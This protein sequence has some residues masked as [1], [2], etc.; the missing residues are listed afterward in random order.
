MKPLNPPATDEKER[1][2]MQPDIQ[3]LTPEK[4]EDFF[5]FFEHIAFAHHPEWGCD[6][7]CCFFHAKSRKAW[8]DATRESNIKAAREMILAGGMRGLLAYADGK[9]VGWCHFDLLKNLPGA[10]VF[11]SE[12]ASD[13][14]KSAAIVCFTIA[15][16]YR[17]Q[18]VATKLL[19]KAMEELKELGVTRVEAYP[20]IK[21]ESQ[22]HNYLGPIAMYEAQG[23]HVVRQ[24]ESHALVERML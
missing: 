10:K 1:G 6:C 9:P 22:E 18:G 5:E 23:F 20:V 14:E 12:L 3:R 4:V 15:Q 11:F 19:Q 13:D 21:D 2:N 17:S 24:T 8:E 7:F 16:G